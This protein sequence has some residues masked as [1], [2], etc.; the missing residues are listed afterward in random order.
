[1]KDYE[2]SEFYDEDEIPEPEEDLEVDELC[3]SCGSALFEN[4]EGDWYCKICGGVWDPDDVGTDIEEDDTP[5]WEEDD[6]E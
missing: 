5:E 2:P 4:D 3:P 1:M 6:I